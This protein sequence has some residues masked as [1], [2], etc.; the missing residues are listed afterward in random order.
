MIPLTRSRLPELDQFDGGREHNSEITSFTYS[1]LPSA[2]QSGSGLLTTAAV[3]LILAGIS[4]F[5]MGV[6]GAAAAVMQ[7]RSM[8]AV[9]YGCVLLVFVAIII[10]IVLG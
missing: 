1:S 6:L 9:Y 8:L 4:L 7:S 2:L 5:I 3:I 10:C